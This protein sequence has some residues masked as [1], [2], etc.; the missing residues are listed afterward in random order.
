MTPYL[1]VII[2]IRVCARGRWPATAGHMN[3]SKDR[4]NVVRRVYRDQRR[5]AFYTK[6]E[7]DPGEELLFDYG[8][9]YWRD[10]ND[11]VD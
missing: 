7:I 10:R 5:V 2:L 9:E 4:A 6:R 1:L 11:L 3:H 8:D